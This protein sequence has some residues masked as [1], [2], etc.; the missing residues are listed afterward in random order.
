MFDFLWR[1]VRDSNPRTSCPVSGFQDRRIRPLCQP[2]KT[3]FTTVLSNRRF[4]SCAN[5]VCSDLASQSRPSHSTAASNHPK[6]FSRRFFQTGGF[7]HAQTLFALTS[8]RSQDRRIRPR[9][10]TILDPFLP[11]LYFNTQN[12]KLF[13]FCCTIKNN[14]ANNKHYPR[15]HLSHRQ[16]P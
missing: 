16:S 3:F 10:P 6:L 2:S 11:S 5:S 4:W 1:M 8:L 9:L 12:V 15:Q 14:Y 7:G 13:L